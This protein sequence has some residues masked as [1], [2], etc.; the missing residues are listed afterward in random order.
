MEYY[1]YIYIHIYTHLHTHIKINYIFSNNLE[2]ICK[3]TQALLSHLNCLTS[4]AGK[5]LNPQVPTLPQT[6]RLSP[7]H[8]PV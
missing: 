2:L 8:L 4:I 7:V 1:I 3:G 6:P 5:Q